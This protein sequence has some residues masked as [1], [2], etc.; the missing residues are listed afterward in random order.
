[1]VLSCYTDVKVKLFDY[2]PLGQSTSKTRQ[3][4]IIA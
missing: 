1:M 4:N 2:V 3:K